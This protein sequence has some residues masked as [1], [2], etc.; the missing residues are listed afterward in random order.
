MLIG[1]A[2]VYERFAP[3]TPAGGI[4]AAG[5]T[6]ILAS[7]GGEDHASFKA[8]PAKH[9]QVRN[10]TTFGVLRLVLHTSGYSW[11]FL[12]DTSSGTFTDSGSRSCH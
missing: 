1:H 5:V 12:P 6:E 3:Q 8:T 11:T 7:T 4:S 9:S 10:N 2:H